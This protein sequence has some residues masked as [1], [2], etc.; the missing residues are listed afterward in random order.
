MSN[1]LLYY[2]DN[3]DVLRRHVPAESVD[4]V[5]L[6]PPFNSAADYNA[7]FTEQ[8]GS[9]SAAQIRAFEDTWRW[10]Q[11]AAAAY[12]EGVEAGGR[13]ADALRGF[14]SFLGQTDMLA[15]LS[16]M[17][18][19]LVEL[20]RALKPTGSIY[21]HCDKTASHY[22]KMLM[23]SVFG[24][25][26]Y[27][28]EITWR[29][30]HAHGNAGRNY[31]KV[32]DV[33]LFYHVTSKYCWNQPYVP[34]EG[35][36]IE[37]RFSGRD[38]DGRR[39]QSVTLRNPGPRPN[40]HYPFKANNGITYQPHPNGWSC[41]AERMLKYDRE[42]RLHFPKKRDGQL[43][44]KMYLDESPGVKV[45]DLWDDIFPV[46]SQAEERLGY[47]TQKPEA[48]LERIIRASSNEGD[49]VLDPFCGCG[50]AIAVAERLKRRWI[51][52]D[53]THLAITLM[54]KRLG[55]A[56]GKDTR[57]RVIGEPEDVAGAAALA[58]SDPYQF[59]WWALGLVGA[60]PAEQKKGADK[61]IDGRLYFHDEPEGGETKQVLFSVK[62][63]HVGVAQVR[64]LR[65]VL[66]R[67]SA[68]IGALISMEEPTQPMRAEAASAGFYLSPW[69]SRHA[70]LQLLTVAKLLG[71]ERLDYPPSQQTNVT[72]KKAPRSG[73]SVREAPT[74]FGSKLGV[75]VHEPSDD[76]PI[77][78]PSRR[79]KKQ[80][81]SR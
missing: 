27:S 19:R 68:S 48:L 44:L 53:V 65:G 50:T 35:D 1:N 58:A 59:Q 73:T 6:D 52:I 43:R 75:E 18:P 15:Y 10:D 36:Y 41:D 77:E 34:F 78:P 47:P 13:V 7:F 63:G 55:D 11:G 40:L 37:K 29:R 3:L 45:S 31:G 38:D 61:G 17:A 46:N 69:G 64:D 8:D 76:G 54:K 12:Q 60:R 32:C 51:G 62:A 42:G 70:R 39:W 9:R 2:G 80:G 16:M 23:D 72:F 81:H 71:G 66:E 25:E 79:P 4:L 28:S 21:L 14:R 56:F 30:T 26:H 49:V 20:R 24:P 5:Y 33:L 57:F 74:L 67:E 22:L